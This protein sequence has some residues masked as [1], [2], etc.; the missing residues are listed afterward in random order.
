MENKYE[1]EKFSKI[2]SES[3]NYTDVCRNLRIGLTYGNR[4]TIKNYIDEYKLDINH[5]YIPSSSGSKKKLDLDNEILITDIKMLGYSGTGRKYSVS[6][7][8][9]RKWLK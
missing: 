5:F 8:A 1:K 6:D 3:I 2:I 7:N 9:I 4:Q